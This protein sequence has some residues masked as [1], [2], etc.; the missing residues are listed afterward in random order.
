M[1]L[2]FDYIR[3][4]SKGKEFWAAEFQGGPI[5]SFLHKG[6]TPAKEDIRRWVLTALSTGINGLSFWN[7]RVEI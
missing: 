3:G 5:V 6:R 7:H 4:A 1:S 2:C